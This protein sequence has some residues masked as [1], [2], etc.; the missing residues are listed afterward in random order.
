MGAGLGQ[1]QRRRQDLYTA[2]FENFAG[3]VAFTDHEVGRLLEAIYALPDADNALIL[4]VTSDN[5]ASAEGGMDGTLNEIKALNGVPTTTEETLEGIDKLGGPESEPH[6]PVGWAWAGNTPFQ[7]VKQ[8]VSHL[9]GTRVGMVASWPA[10]FQPTTGSATSSCTSSTS[11][12]RSS[13]RRACP[14]RTQ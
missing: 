2:L 12:P 9:G 8:V 14:F 5:G 4:Y 3:F 1:P 6:Y 7:W 13:R 10:R 11:R